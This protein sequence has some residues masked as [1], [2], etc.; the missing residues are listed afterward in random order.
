MAV[1]EECKLRWVAGTV[2]RGVPGAA[3][4]RQADLSLDNE[5]EVPI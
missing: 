3:Q 4:H 1:K 5:I 2:W